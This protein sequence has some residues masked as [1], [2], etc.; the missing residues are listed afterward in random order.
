LKIW[1]AARRESDN[2]FDRPI[3]ILLR[4]R[5]GRERENSQQSRQD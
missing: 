5:L 2:D 3:R 4:L 1:A